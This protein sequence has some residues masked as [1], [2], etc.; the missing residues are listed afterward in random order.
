MEYDWKVLARLIKYFSNCS[1]YF[2]T[3][4]SS[5]QSEGKSNR[6]DSKQVSQGEKLKIQKEKFSDLGGDN[7]N[8]TY[9]SPY[10]RNFCWKI[11]ESKPYV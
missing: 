11:Q 5:A 7:L 3:Q 4:L 10:R 8:I 1:A 6:P 2:L 9:F